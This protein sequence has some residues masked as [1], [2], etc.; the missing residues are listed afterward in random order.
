MVPSPLPFIYEACPL[1]RP[2]HA[3][4]GSHVEAHL[5]YATGELANSPLP[6]ARWDACRFAGS[7]LFPAIGEM[8]IRP[9]LSCHRRDGCAVAS[10]QFAIGS[11]ELEC[12]SNSVV[13]LASSVC[14]F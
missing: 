14:V 11:G 2:M 10:L 9:S 12:K 3:A 7:Q 4:W 13:G 1:P 6:L 8:K 5:A